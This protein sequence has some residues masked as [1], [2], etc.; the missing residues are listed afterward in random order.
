MQQANKHQFIVKLFLAPGLAFSLSQCAA[1]PVLEPVSVNQIPLPQV[2]PILTIESWPNDDDVVARVHIVTIPPNYPVEVAVDDGLKTVEDFATETNALAV[3]NGGFFDPNNAQTTSFVTVNG[4]LAADPR[5][6]ARLIDNPDLTIYTEQ[7]LNRSEFRRYDCDGDI[8][9]DITFHDEPVPSGCILH[10]ALGAGPQLLPDN[11]SQVEGFID[12]GDGLLTRDA[13]GSQH[14]NARSAIGIKSDG[15]IVWIMVAQATP[16]G[17]MTLFELAD[18]MAD[19]GIQKA[20]N[21]DGGSSSA[22]YFAQRVVSGSDHSHLP[23]ETNTAQTSPNLRPIK[24]VLTL[25]LA[26]E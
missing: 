3:I 2:Q 13:I 4:T 22:L 11:T 21:L 26:Q 25:R 12:Y 19:V 1:Q 7:I 16:S 9:Y 10:T 14:P 15:T 20:L 5:N 24:S 23:T 8:R 18:Y 17:G 6:N